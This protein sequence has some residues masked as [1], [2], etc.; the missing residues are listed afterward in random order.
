[1]SK[2]VRDMESKRYFLDIDLKEYYPDIYYFGKFVRFRECIKN[3]DEMSEK[4]RLGL[5]LANYDVAK[6]YVFWKTCGFLSFPDYNFSKGFSCNNKFSA[7][8]TF[9]FDN[10][11]LFRGVSKNIEQNNNL[12]FIWKI[13]EISTCLVDHILSIPS[14]KTE[15]IEMVAIPQDVAYYKFMKSTQIITNY[16]KKKFNKIMSENNAKSLIL[17]TAICLKDMEGISDILE[18]SHTNIFAH[19]DD[20]GFSPISRAFWVSN[21]LTEERTGKVSDILGLIEKYIDKNKNNPEFKKAH[22]HREDVGNIINCLRWEINNGNISIFGNILNSIYVDKRI[23]NYI[24]ICCINNLWKNIYSTINKR[25]VEYIKQ[26]LIEY[27]RSGKYWN[28]EIIMKE[29]LS[30]SIDPEKFYFHL[31]H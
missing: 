18:N 2:I 20:S 24:L 15:K 26:V 12:Y 14:Q 4:E 19:C 27:E 16:Y 7:I 22:Y 8:D 13:K 5:I 23:T 29:L 1:M 9:L 21:Q 17:S 11:F 3:R 31:L 6:Y 28:N 30:L 25:N 10:Y